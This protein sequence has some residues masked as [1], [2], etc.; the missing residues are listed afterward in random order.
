[1]KILKILLAIA[2][3]ILDFPF[4]PLASARL[5]KRESIFYLYGPY[6]F[7]ARRVYPEF[8]AML[9]IIDIGHAEL[10]ERI[11]TARTEA[12]AVESIE[13]DLFGRVTGMFLGRS[14]RPRFSPSEET[15][16]PRSVKLAWRINKAFDWTH[17]L[18]RQVYDILSDDRVKDKG[19]AI[20]EAL[21]YYLTEPDR[22]FPFKLKSMRL[23]EGQPFSGY[24]RQKYPKFNGA[25]WGYHWLQL[26]ANEALLEP[27]PKVRREKIDLAVN[28]FK[29]MFI[30]PARLPKHMPMAHEISPAFAARFPD[31]AVTFDNLHT[32]HDI[33]MDLLTN[34]SVRDKRGEAYRQLKTILY[35][36]GD[37]E[38]AATRPLPP[39]PLDRQGALLQMNQEEHMA[40]MTMSTDEQMS[41][42]EMS[43]EER[44][45]KI[46]R[47]TGKMEHEGMGE[48]ERAP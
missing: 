31:V 9:N 5:E 18:H 39:I 35:P 8:D 41:F 36:Q 22:A 13:E 14:R 25:I 11:I 21:N 17:S 47:L 15:I 43:S 24:W 38:T 6:N 37:L 23:M 27:D 29:R 48:H 45:E 44:K 19:R 7:S 42:L 2:I 16:A 12:E 3:L 10:A 33:Y 20:D 1:M 28:E 46:D 26:A 30:E 32:F 4:A 34:P 40:M